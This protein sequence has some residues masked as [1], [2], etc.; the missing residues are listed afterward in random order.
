M[1]THPDATPTGVPADHPAF[2]CPAGCTD[3]WIA[4]PTQE[5]REREVDC[6]C[7]SHA[8]APTGYL[9][10]V[11]CTDCPR[12]LAPT[13]VRAVDNNHVLCRDCYLDRIDTRRDAEPERLDLNKLAHDVCG[14]APEEVA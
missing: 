6:E 12:W 5:N 8:D 2:A 3:G 14:I 11:V 1:T 10:E 4:A 9:G 13:T 7:E